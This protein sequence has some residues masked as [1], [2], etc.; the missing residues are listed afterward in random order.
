MSRK[1]GHIEGIF[2]GDTFANRVLLAESKVHR[3]LQ[4]GI[5]GSAI[6]GA[7]SIVLSGG[8]EDDEDL[9]NEIIYTGQGGRGILSKEQVADQTL[10]RG[11]MALVFSYEHALPIR[12]IRG[13][14]SLSK[15]APSNG[16]RYDGL[17]RVQS[18]W[19]EKGRSG[20]VVW[21]YRL[22]KIDVEAIEE[23]PRLISE[24]EPVYNTP[25]RREYTSYRIIRDS[26]N[27]Q[28]VKKLYQY[29]CQICLIQIKSVTGYYAEAAHIKALGKP[30]FGPD[31]IENM[32]CLCP[33][34]H[35]MFD[36]GVITINNDLSLIG[37]VSGSLHTEREHRIDRSCLAYHRAHLY[38][39]N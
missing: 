27:A 37:A 23:P 10:T 25:G 24:S 13:A 18:Y 36:L 12:V 3:P 7:D 8:Y 1:F 39:G 9:G 32:I 4:A 15:Y 2:E 22:L 33:N 17:F 14:N 34:H 11:N 16:Y 6:E 29:K 30:H 28:Y 5:S 35:V 38:K 20:Y 21:K 31:V 26:A 19:K